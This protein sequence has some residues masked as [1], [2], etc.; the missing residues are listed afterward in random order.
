[1]LPTA[2]TYDCKCLDEHLQ[3]IRRVKYLDESGL[4]QLFT[5]T[6]NAKIIDAPNTFS[7]LL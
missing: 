7:Q 4:L 1:M 2:L 6:N 5:L 3:T